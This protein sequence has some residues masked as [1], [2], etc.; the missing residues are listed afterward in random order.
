MSRLDRGNHLLAG[1]GSQDQRHGTNCFSEKAI[2]KGISIQ[3][4]LV[5]TAQETYARR[6]DFSLRHMGQNRMGAK[7]HTTVGWFVGYVEAGE[8]VWILCDQH[9]D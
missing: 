2:C 1:R 5:R 8:K 3:G 6:A 4:L 7:G 9:R